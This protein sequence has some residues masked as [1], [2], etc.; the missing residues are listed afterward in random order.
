MTTNTWWVKQVRSYLLQ[1][2]GKDGMPTES[3]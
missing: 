1:Q 2:L 3:Y